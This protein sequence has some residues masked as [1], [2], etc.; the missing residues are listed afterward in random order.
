MSKYA[1]KYAHKEM[2]SSGYLYHIYESPTLKEDIH[3]IK[4]NTAVMRNRERE[5]ASLQT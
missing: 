3:K 4:I 5:R 2:I 1:K